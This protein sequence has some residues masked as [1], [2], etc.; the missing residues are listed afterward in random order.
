MLQHDRM[1]LQHRSMAFQRI[2]DTQVKFHLADAVAHVLQETIYNVPVYCIYLCTAYV[3]LDVLPCL[4]WQNSLV[5]AF[6]HRCHE[7]ALC[8]TE[9]VQYVHT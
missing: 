2:V 8:S 1:L 7:A 4:K 6:M 9:F 5:K 3:L